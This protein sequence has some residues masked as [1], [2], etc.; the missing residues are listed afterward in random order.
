MKTTFGT[1]AMLLLAVV[2]AHRA[3]AGE[4]IRPIVF[5]LAD[6]WRWPAATNTSA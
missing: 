4:V 6:D 1:A 3:S 5:I 2:V